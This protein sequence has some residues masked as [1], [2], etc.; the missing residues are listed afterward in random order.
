[1]NA[2]LYGI[3]LQFKLDIRSKTMLITC[4]VVPLLFFAFMGGIFTSV[5]PEAANT[6][7]DDIRGIH[8]SADRSAALLNG[9]IR[10]RDKKSL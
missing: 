4:Y 7:I 3:A 6:L 2:F 8:G 5:N 1:M 9:N 10:Q